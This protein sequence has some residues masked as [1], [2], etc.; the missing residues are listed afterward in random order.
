MPLGETGVERR[1]APSLSLSPVQINTSPLHCESGTEPLTPHG[2]VVQLKG[3][4][5]LAI[6]LYHLIH[7]E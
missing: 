4:E 6:I 2:S 3:D 7:T 5:A 1:A